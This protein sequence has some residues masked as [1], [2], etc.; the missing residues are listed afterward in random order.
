MKQDRGTTSI[1]GGSPWSVRLNSTELFLVATLVLRRGYTS[2]SVQTGGASLTG[3]N[4]FNA[5]VEVKP[6]PYLWKSLQPQRAFAA[7]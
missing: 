5:G 6:R 1:P 7:E 2:T 4:G 3:D